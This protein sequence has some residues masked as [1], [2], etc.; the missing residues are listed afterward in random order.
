MLAG[1]GDLHTLGGADPGHQRRRAVAFNLI[2]NPGEP[3]LAVEF[4]LGLGEQP[5]PAGVVGHDTARIPGIGAGC[6][7]FGG[8]RLQPVGG[9]LQRR[10]HFGLGVSGL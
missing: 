5:L 2:F 1:L 3:N 9:I 6:D 7:L 10:S 4:G 8:G